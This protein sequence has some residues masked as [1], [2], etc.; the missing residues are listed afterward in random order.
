M[1]STAIDM[2]THYWEPLTAWSDYIDPGFRDRAP[3]FL[4]DD[5]RLLMRVGESVYPSMPNHPGLGKVYGPDE[6]LNEQTKLDKR[7]STDAARRLGEMDDNHTRVHVIYPTLGMVGFNGIRDGDLAGACARAY[8]R[9]CAEFAA[10]NPQRLKPAML[11][12]FNHPDIAVRELDY[13]YTQCGL[14]VAFANPTP[15]NEVPWNSEVY[16]PIWRAM[17]LHGVTLTW[18]ESTVGAGPTSVGINRYW[19]QG[20]MVYLCV[21]TVEPQLATMDMIIGGVLFRHPQLRMGMLEAHV[22]WI[23][24][25]L[26]LLD[27]K[28]GPAHEVRGGTLGMSP[29]DYFRRQC[30]AAAFSDDVGIAE[31]TDYLGIESGNIVF[32]SDWPHKSL[33]DGDNSVDGFLAR[34]DLSEALKTRILE[35]NPSRWLNL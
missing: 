30:F 11:I 35:T 21:H 2:D 13:A 32:S 16:D 27:Y 1:A 19:G 20:N 28:V 26:Q 15:P 4:E 14:D 34:N 7:M 24:G 23:P 6:T 25:W 33:D 29:S 10:A 9:Y 17:E 18:H 5:G 8:N 31:T 12:P 3:A 22:S